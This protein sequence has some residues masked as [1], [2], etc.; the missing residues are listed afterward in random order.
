MTSYYIS[1][2]VLRYTLTVEET[3][4][5]YVEAYNSVGYVRSS[6]SEYSPVSKSV[7]EFS[8][9]GSLSFSQFIGAIIAGLALLLILLLLV[10]IVPGAVRRRLMRQDKDQ[11]NLASAFYPEIDRVVC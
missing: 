7:E 8:P 5:F 2:F 11:L 1:A 10:F 6:S 9:L 3:F 4:F